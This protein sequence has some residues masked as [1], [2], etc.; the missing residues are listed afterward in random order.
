MTTLAIYLVVLLVVGAL[1]FLLASLVFGRGEELAPLPAGTTPTVLPATDV[2]GT[3]VREL[4][5]QQVVRGYKA[6]EVDWA[7]ERLAAEIERLHAEIEGLTAGA[8]GLTA[9]A[10]RLT[11]ERPGRE[12]DILGPEPDPTEIE[13][14]ENESEDAR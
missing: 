14:P 13:T 1:L 6:G 9:G 10:E 7:L 8:E 5:F 4:R 12:P 2:T 11:A 3:D